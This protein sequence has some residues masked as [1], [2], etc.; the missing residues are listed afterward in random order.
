MEAD[1]IARL[2]AQVRERRRSL[3]LTQTDLAD[4][5]GC[6]SRFVRSL[7]A[8]KGTVRVD[9]LLDVLDVLGLELIARLRSTP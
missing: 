2:A 1:A 4:L 7:E 6:S 8:G 3:G 9:K 5:A